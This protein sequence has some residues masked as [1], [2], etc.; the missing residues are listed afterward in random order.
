MDK[1]GTMLTETRDGPLAILTI[2]RP[3]RRNAL[4]SGTVAALSGA[5]R[6]LDADAAVRVIVITGAAPGFCAGSDLKELATLDLA[7]M[8]AHEAETAA[9]ARTITFLSKPV[10]AAVAGFALGGGFQLAVSCDIVVSEAD[11]RWHMPEVR[12]GWIPPWGL[13]VVTARC[14]PVAA[15]RLVWGAE[16]LTAAE[17]HRAGVV[18]VLAEPGGA[19]A[20]ALA[21]G[22]R[23]AALPAE[24]VASTKHYFAARIMR[25]GEADDSEANR[26]FLA[27]CAGAQAK[28]TFKKFGMKA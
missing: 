20:A 7:G 25:S 10:I 24:S 8:S 22:R 9:M 15:R 21:E 14:G 18:D 13:T 6:R 5:F 19:L 26:M 4:D 2:D 27:D 12:I 3:N 23:L 16:A 17:A 1:D 28:A 11:V